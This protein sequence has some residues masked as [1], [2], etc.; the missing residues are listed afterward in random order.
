MSAV[1]PDPAPDDI[2]GVALAMARVLSAGAT[3]WCCA[4]GWPHHAQHLAVEFVHPVIVGKRALPAVAVLDTDPAAAMRAVVRAG[5]AAVVVAAGDDEVARDLLARAEAWGLHRLWIGAGRRPDPGAAEAVLWLDDE[6]TRA[7]FG[8]GIVRTYH[9]LWELIHVC[10]EHPGL[11]QEPD[12]GADD[13]C[14]TC[15]DEGRVAEVMASREADAVTVRTATG[16]EVVDASLVED[17]GVGDLLVVHAGIAIA[18]V[19]TAGSVSR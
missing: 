17:V 6:P 15:A 14:I 2:A 9:V 4:P 19:E 12:G 11:L 13:V 7:N 5:D 16:L 3:M 8:G 10:F 1:P 18:R